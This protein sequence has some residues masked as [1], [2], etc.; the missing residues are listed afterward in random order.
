L[1]HHAQVFEWHN[2]DGEDAVMVARRKKHNDLANYLQEVGMKQIR[3]QTGGN[4]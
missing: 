3:D 4:F 1:D 2:D